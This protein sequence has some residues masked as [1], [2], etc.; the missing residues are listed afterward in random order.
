MMFSEVTQ[1][2]LSLDML[3]PVEGQC[4]GSSR[5]GCGW[6]PGRTAVCARSCL[7]QEQ[8]LNQAFGHHQDSRVGG[9]LS[10]GLEGAWGRA[11]R[12]RRA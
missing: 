8:G 12:I 11:G 5:P 3:T 7:S 2:P 10:E 1:S 9:P 4:P 6:E